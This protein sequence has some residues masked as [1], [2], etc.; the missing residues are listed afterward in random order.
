MSKESQ[1]GFY[2]LMD[3]VIDSKEEQALIGIILEGLEGVIVKHSLHFDFQMINNQDEYEALIVGLNLVK[4][5][6]LNH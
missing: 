1:L 4:D 6:G 2:T 5:M 3:H